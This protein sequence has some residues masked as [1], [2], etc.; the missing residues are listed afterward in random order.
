MKFKGV[1]LIAK[2]FSGPVSKRSEHLEEPEK[3][4]R[5]KPETQQFPY[6]T[7]HRIPMSLGNYF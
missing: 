6:L 7:L 2:V 4:N 5:E 3:N 1:F